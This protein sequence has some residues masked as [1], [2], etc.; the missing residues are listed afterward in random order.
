VTKRRVHVSTDAVL[1]LMRSYRNEAMRCGRARAYLAGCVMIG[2]DLDA[3]L[4][5]LTRMY[6]RHVRRVGEHP[7]EMR[8]LGKL[9]SLAAKI[10]WL[11]GSSLRA[12]RR[13]VRS[14]D[15]VHAERL[16]RRGQFPHIRAAEFH[17][18][19]DDMDEVSDALY[20]VV[21]KSLRRQMT[22]EGLL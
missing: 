6:P 3:S 18:R 5:A 21:E 19:G 9:V 17:A 2:S 13:I 20:R 8:G 16:G 7:S 14:R 4:T 12:A 1:M 11:A 22:K 10:G 15:K